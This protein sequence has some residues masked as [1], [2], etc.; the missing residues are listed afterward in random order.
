MLLNLIKWDF[1]ESGSSVQ[2]GRD[3]RE[4]FVVSYLGEA[5][6]TKQVMSLGIIKFLNTGKPYIWEIYIIIW[7]IKL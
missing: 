2:W 3:T 1:V 5:V 7:D 4:S 6:V